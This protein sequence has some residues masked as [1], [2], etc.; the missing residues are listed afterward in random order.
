LDDF[1]KP[2]LKDELLVIQPRQRCGDTTMKRIIT[3][4]CAVLVSMQAHSDVLYLECTGTFPPKY[5][6]GEYRERIMLD[7]DKETGTRTWG[8][9]T[10][11]ISEVVVTPDFYVG[12]MPSA[13][14][15]KVKILQLDRRDGS[16][17]F[18]GAEGTCAKTDPPKTLF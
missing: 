1:I 3:A 17:M 5:G 18:N 8:N 12:Y 14:Q 2:N 7:T 9:T 16:A 6:G 10:G 15:G 13:V 4:V 11:I